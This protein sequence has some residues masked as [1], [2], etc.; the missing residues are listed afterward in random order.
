MTNE[1]LFEQM[2]E[3]C[4]EANEME[5]KALI[6]RRKADRLKKEYIEA[7]KETNNE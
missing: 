7:M 5:L 1:M 6:M 3:A 4:R 2:V